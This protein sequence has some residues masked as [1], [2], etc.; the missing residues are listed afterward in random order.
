MDTNWCYYCGS[1]INH[2]D[3]DLYCSEKCK[4]KDEKHVPIYYIHKL[5]YAKED[6]KRNSS[7]ILDPTYIGYIRTTIR[8]SD[9]SYDTYAPLLWS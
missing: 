3:T 1:H 9:T 8:L 5:S 4:K 2:S 6:R 7:L